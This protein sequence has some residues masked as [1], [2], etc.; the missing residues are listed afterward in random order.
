MF[1]KL[2]HWVIVS[3]VACTL[4]ACGGGQAEQ[5]GGPAV[6]PAL[7]AAAPVV[8]A[9]APTT[10]A[11][12]LAVTAA[13]AAP[14][15]LPQSVRVAPAAEM[16]PGHRAAAELVSAQPSAQADVQAQGVLHVQGGASAVT[17]QMQAA[18]LAAEHQARMAELAAAEQAARWQ[19]AMG[20]ADEEAYLALL[21]YHENAE[22]QAALSGVRH[23][24]PTDADCSNPRFLVCAGN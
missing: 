2:S 8:T 6:A 3:A 15:E 17:P 10:G 23:R 18:Q 20:N 1:A 13:A 16:Q 22:R 5:A 24:K 12:G 7:T 21:M 19:A 14:A 9:A 11:T 4:S